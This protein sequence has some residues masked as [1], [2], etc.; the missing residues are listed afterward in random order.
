MSGGALFEGM[1]ILL[2]GFKRMSELE[3]AEDR[4]EFLALLCQVSLELNK[5]KQADLLPR[6]FLLKP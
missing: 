1:N 5:H 3:R 4:Y 2:R 6:L